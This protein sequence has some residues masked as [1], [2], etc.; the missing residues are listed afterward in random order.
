M[1]YLRFDHGEAIE[2]LRDTVRN[3]AAKEIAPRAAEI[4]TFEKRVRK[5]LGRGRR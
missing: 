1:T 5:Q 3:F 2:M 4:A